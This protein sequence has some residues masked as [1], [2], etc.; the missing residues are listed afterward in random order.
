MWAAGPEARSERGKKLSSQPTKSSELCRGEQVKTDRTQVDV[1]IL[2]GSRVTSCAEDTPNL[3]YV[4][5]GL[6]MTDP[7]KMIV[8]VTIPVI[9]LQDG[10]I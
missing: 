9:L 8:D 7:G 5:R 4:G 6:V 2:L 10:K 1:R 3:G